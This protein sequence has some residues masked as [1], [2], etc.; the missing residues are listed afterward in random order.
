MKSRKIRKK[1]ESEKHVARKRLAYAFVAIVT[2][3]CLLTYA[4]LNS[5]NPIPIDQTPKVAIVDH[6]SISQPNRTFSQTIQAI[7]NQTGLEVDYYPGE[8]VT[9]DFYRNLPMHNYK[10]I[11]LRVHSTGTV[12]VKDQPQLH[13]N[14]VIFF[15]SEQ[16]STTKYVPEQLDARLAQA[17][18]PDAQPPGYFGVTPLFIKDSLAGRFNNT[19]I[20]TMGCE[21][22][23]YSTMAQAFIE[24]GAGAYIG[25]N[26]SVMASH[27]D[28]ATTVLLHNLVIEKQSIQDAVTNTMKEVGP[29]PA[30]QSVLLFY[31]GEAGSYTILLTTHNTDTNVDVAHFASKKKLS[32]SNI[33]I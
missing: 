25:W 22:L 18:F 11:I 14:L 13:A 2:I 1:V 28:G 6:L 8:E 5:Q 23:K 26:G 24:R 3:L 10:I 30:Y 29:D 15:T 17:N 32:T 19:V 9:V 4:K 31:P 7:I 21:G 20:I 33:E 12:S 27:T 16:Y